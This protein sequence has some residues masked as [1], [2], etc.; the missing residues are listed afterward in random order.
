[1]RPR[2]VSREGKRAG[3]DSVERHDVR[4]NSCHIGRN[5][6]HRR[7]RA[8]RSHTPERQAAGPSRPGGIDV[9]DNGAPDD[10][11]RG[12]TPRRRGTEPHRGR[13]ESA[14]GRLRRGGAPLGRTT[15]RPTRS[16]TRCRRTTTRCSSFTVPRRHEETRD[17]TGSISEPEG[18]M[19]T[20]RATVTL[21][22][23]TR[24]SGIRTRRPCC[25]SMASAHNAS[26]MP[27]S[28]ASSSATRVS[29]S[30]DSTDRD[31]GLSSKLDG[32]RLHPW[33]HGR[34]R[35]VAVLDAVGSRAGPSD[36]LFDGGHDRPT[37][38]HRPPGAGALHDVGDV[39]NGS[40][41]LRRE[42]E[43]G[44]GLSAGTAGVVALGLHRPPGGRPPRLRIQA[45]MAR[46]RC[47]PGPG[48]RCLRPLL[49]PRGC[50]SSDESG[51]TGTA[52]VPRNSPRKSTCP[53][54]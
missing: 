11:R 32:N 24:S 13:T 28:G 15:P 18:H 16:C 5:D 22:S 54:W 17:R 9:D 12:A 30:C 1:M 35:A 45:R 51:H 41:R 25:W 37:V 3:A 8:A 36:G 39:P 2:Q 44:P 43:G 53:P 46:R 47:P 27:W 49:L 40:A 42:L 50:R 6:E 52:H 38:R 14:G 26:T 21:G 48:R 4:T 29:T 31:V 7:P 20:R 10:V 19:S 33:R 23:T 34:W